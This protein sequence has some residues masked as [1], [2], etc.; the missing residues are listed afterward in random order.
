MFLSAP[1]GYVWRGISYSQC[2]IVRVSST[3]W[4]P[5]ASIFDAAYQLAR[6]LWPTNAMAAPCAN[7]GLIPRSD[8]VVWLEPNTRRVRDWGK[9]GSEPHIVHQRGLCYS[10][11][12]G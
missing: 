12:L 8:L 3:N 2:A 7:V 4:L 5:I 10:L 1:C 6:L 9:S 11:T